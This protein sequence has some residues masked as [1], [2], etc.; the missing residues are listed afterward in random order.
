MSGAAF[1]RWRQSWG[2][3]LQQ[4]AEARD[5]DYHAVIGWEAGYSAVPEP[6][7]AWAR[8]IGDPPNTHRYG[9]TVAGLLK[10][11]QAHRM[12]CVELAAFLHVGEQTVGKWLYRGAPLPP[13]IVTW[14]RAGAPAKW[15][16]WGPP[17]AVPGY[18]S[19]GRKVGHTAQLRPHMRLQHYGS[20]RLVNRLLREQAG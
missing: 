15:E 20:L 10:Y 8:A 14:L 7:A 5:Y 19:P 11:L 2:W 13:P 1:R 18:R 12:R 16:H 6:V 9:G 4:I 3:S 17:G